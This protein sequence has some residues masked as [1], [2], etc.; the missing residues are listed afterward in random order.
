MN[1]GILASREELSQLTDRI[2]RKPFDAFYDRLTRRCSLILEAAPASESHWR[3]MWD[4]G[5]WGSAIQAAR[6][7]QGRVLDLAIAHNI[8]PDEA[9]RDRAIEELKNLVSW[10]TWVDPCHPDLAADLCTAE[11]AVAALVGLDWLWEDMS[12]ADRLRIL[13][14]VRDKAI[15]PY[16]ASVADG[17]WWHTCCTSWNAVVNGG[18]GLAA[19]ALSDENPDADLAYREAT[20]SLGHFFEAF[21][22]EGGWE[23]GTGYWGYAMRYILLFSE[24]SGRLNGDHHLL[25]KRGMELTG[26][27]PVYF[28]PNGHAASFGDSPT[29]PLMGTMYLLVKHF[30]LGEVSWWLDTYAFHHDVSSDGYSEAGLALMF[31][32]TDPPAPTGGHLHPL[33]VYNEIGWAAMADNWPNPSM[34]VALK[35]GDLAASHSQHD[36]NAIQLQVDGEML[37]RDLGTPAY[38]AD[39]FSEARDEFYEVQAQAH[40]TL[41]VGKRDHAVDAQ[42]SIIDALSDDAF[43]WVACDSGQAT[44]AE[45]HFIRHVVMLVDAQGHG[46][47][48]LV[49]D[50]LTNA[51]DES[52][53]LF[54]HTA[55]DIELAADGLAGRIS[56]SRAELHFSFASTPAGR[57]HTQTIQRG[58]QDHDNILHAEFAKISE[59]LLLTVFSREPLPKPPTV[60]EDSTGATVTAC[61]AKLKFKTRRRHLVL[62]KVL[63]S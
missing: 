11:A 48:V 44:G 60:K 38:S 35:T 16:L 5:Q 10:T 13:H 14:A 19:L 41:I 7:V 56:G 55:G 20:A 3:T 18:I 52:A 57:L 8:D 25:H 62:E 23:E 59:G 29:V 26:L 36:M 33:K 54:W 51:D 42:G 28:T 6:T 40:N 37:L 63:I 9:Y 1:R 32:P 39:Y 24:A 58:G 12:Q 53:D 61:G 50:H 43:R 34:Y 30:G 2:G 47:A 31:R 15:A 21:G 46:K 49:L 17:V 45:V 27:F 4:R 22:G